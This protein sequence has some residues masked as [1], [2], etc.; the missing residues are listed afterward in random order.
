ME[1]GG[2][3]EEV[4]NRPVPSFPLQ[5]SPR[6]RLEHLWEQGWKRQEEET[7]GASY[8]HEEHGEEIDHGLHVELP[9]GRNAD[10]REESQAAEGGQEKLGDQRAHRKTDGTVESL[11]EEES[12]PDC[13][14]A[15]RRQ[16]E[17]H[18]LILGGRGGLCSADSCGKWAWTF[19]CPHVGVLGQVAEGF[20]QHMGLRTGHTCGWEASPSLEEQVAGGKSGKGP[21]FIY[22]DG[23]SKFGFRNLL[24]MLPL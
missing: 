16:A 6:A 11:E 12:P 22:M 20:G 9:L 5:G 1:L 19:K 18:S 14:A 21:L 4:Q 3:A 2:Y 13:Q 23:V 15:L 7:R 24:C 8:R 10:G 17:S